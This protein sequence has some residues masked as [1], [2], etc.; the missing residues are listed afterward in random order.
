ME[1]VEVEAEV[2]TTMDHSIYKRSIMREESMG[3]GYSDGRRD[4]DVLP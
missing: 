2:M 1:E 3:S 4:D